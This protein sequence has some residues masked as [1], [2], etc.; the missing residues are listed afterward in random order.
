[1][2]DKKSYINLKVW[3]IP[4]VGL[5]IAA[6][7]L[8]FLPEQIPMH[9]DN[10]GGVQMASRFTILLIPAISMAVLA[11]G[12][13][14]PV[15]DPRKASYGQIKREYTI[16]HLLIMLLM[17]AVELFVILS[18]IGVSIDASM[19]GYLVVGVILAAVGNYLPKIPQTYLTG[20]KSIWGYHNKA[21]WTKIHR[22]AG[23][24]WFIGGLAL[25]VLAFVPMSFPVNLIIIAILVIAPRLYGMVVS[26]KMREIDKEN[27]NG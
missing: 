14:V 18:S 2:N 25:I 15:I 19:F 11:L 23:K 10:A 1:M 4:I 24:L 5:V 20:I 3:V 17:L 12:H 16:I 13:V 21:V 6:I 9:W 8:F 27:L 26:L 22:M 7:S